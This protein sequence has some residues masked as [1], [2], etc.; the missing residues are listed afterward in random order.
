[1]FTPTERNSFAPV[2]IDRAWAIIALQRVTYS[3]GLLALGVA[4]E[5]TQL[6]LGDALNFLGNVSQTYREHG[7]GLCTIIE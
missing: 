6:S 3:N 1:M 5:R 7:G 2:V 4:E